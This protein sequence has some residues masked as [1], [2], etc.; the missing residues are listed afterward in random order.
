MIRS[1]QRQG[2]GDPQPASKA[3]M[4]GV[5]N[6]RWDPSNYPDSTGKNAGEG[7]REGISGRGGHVRTESRGMDDPRCAV[8]LEEVEVV[9]SSLK[10]VAADAQ[11]TAVGRAEHASGLSGK[12]GS[13]EAEASGCQVH[14]SDD[15]QVAGEVDT[16]AL[17][18]TL[19]LVAADDEEEEI[20]ADI[21][22]E[23]AQKAEAGD[24]RAWGRLA[25]LPCGHRFHTHW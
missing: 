21:G 10:E 8:C 3:I 5:W 19:A 17:C 24:L 1:R 15:Q 7:S 4:D 13:G 12:T 14:V 9:Q 20:N 18:G 23:E 16:N 22:T 25:Y 2:R 6:G 11:D